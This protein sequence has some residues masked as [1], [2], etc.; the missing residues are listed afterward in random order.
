M[1]DDLAALRQ[2]YR[3]ATLDRNGLAEDPLVQF[4]HWFSE[5]TKAGVVEPNAMVLAT[6]DP[7][8]FPNSRV[9][10][11]KDLE[12]G[13]FTFFTNYLSQKAQE[14]EHG[15]RAASLTFLWKELERQVHVRGTVERVP[16]AESDAYFAKRPYQ[17]QIGAWASAQSTVLP[18]RAAL[19]AAFAA[20]GEKFPP[21]QPVPRPAHWGGFGL[22]PSLLEFWQG[23]SSRLHDRFRYVLKNGQWELHRHAP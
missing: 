18:D 4:S 17:S 20:Y 13:Q 19:E 11:L 16:E 15:Q 2:D 10:L 12:H 9:V 6:V 1:N 5:A 7:L 23:R 21:S 22:R 3:K 14:L 8:G